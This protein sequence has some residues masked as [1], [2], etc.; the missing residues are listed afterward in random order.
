MGREAILVVDANGLLQCPRGELSKLCE[1][2]GLIDICSM[3]HGSE[4]KPATSDPGS[5]RV[6]CITTQG[7]HMALKALCEKA[8]HLLEAGRRFFDAQ[9]LEERLQAPN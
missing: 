7:A 6:N 1:S 8:S 2:T 5:R 4:N 3:M 9:T